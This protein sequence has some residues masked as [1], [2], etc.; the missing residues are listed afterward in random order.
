MIAS[1]EGLLIQRWYQNWG[2]SAL[3]LRIQQPEPFFPSLL[4]L[5]VG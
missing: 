3:V 5:L 1:S 4:K 2:A